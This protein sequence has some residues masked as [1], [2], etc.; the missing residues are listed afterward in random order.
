MLK[1][2]FNL[3]TIK[4]AI[5]QTKEYEQELTSKDVT[6]S[7]NTLSKKNQKIQNLASQICKKIKGVDKRI[8]DYMILEKLEQLLKNLAKKDFQEQLEAIQ[9][10]L[11]NKALVTNPDVFESIFPLFDALFTLK[12]IQRKKI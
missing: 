2:K 10:K 12:A 6:D 1:F 9:N 3:L 4:N 8:R 5:D 7:L 11:Q